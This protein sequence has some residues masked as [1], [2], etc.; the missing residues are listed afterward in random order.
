VSTV[1]AAV[2]AGAVSLG[3]WYF[4]Q[5]PLENRDQAKASKQA[6]VRQLYEESRR[7]V[8][9]SRAQLERNRRAE[10]GRAEYI[11]WRAFL[12]RAITVHN[13]AYQLM[14][15]GRYEAAVARFKKAQKILKDCSGCEPI[16][17]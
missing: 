10:M 15:D 3:Y 16:L 6:E 5:R 4:A 14:Q 17:P 2:L 7:L 9:S 12:R 11:R 1:V 8:V 13:N